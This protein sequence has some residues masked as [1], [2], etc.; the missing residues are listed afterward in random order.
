[1]EKQT[2]KL[3]IK[4]SLYTFSAILM[5]FFLMDA[6]GFI[7]NFALRLLNLVIL[8]VGLHLT[9]RKIRTEFA[10]P[11][12]LKLLF[13]G[14]ALSLITGLSLASF[15]FIYLANNPDFIIEVQ[16]LEIQGKHLNQYSIPML[17][18]IEFFASGYLITF[19]ILQWSKSKIKRKAN[20]QVSNLEVS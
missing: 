8:G 14:M 3:I 12:Y 20:K 9:M 15:L 16:Q 17:V 5:F 6:A 18:F 10:S 1:M 4:N 19:S 13:S 2:Q 11:S 7:H